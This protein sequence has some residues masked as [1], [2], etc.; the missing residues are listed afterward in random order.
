MAAGPDPIGPDRALQLGRELADR[1]Q[2][3]PSHDP[4]VNRLGLA[5]QTGAQH[6]VHAIRADQHV[7]R[8]FAV[9]VDLD[10]RAIS[11]RATTDTALS[12]PDGVG[13]ERRDG[14]AQDAMKIAAMHE[15][16]RRAEP[17]AGIRA[18]IEQRPD[19][20][21][22]PQPHLLALRF[23]HDGCQSVLEAERDQNTRPVRP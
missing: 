3:A 9:T 21:A 15:P 16:I 12:H 13:F 11:L 18:E 17:R 10:D 6:G 20:S 4:G 1:D 22:V 7:A 19:L 2:A 8:L 23:A 14:V 5:E